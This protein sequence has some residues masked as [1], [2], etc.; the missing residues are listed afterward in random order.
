MSDL[1]PYEEGLAIDLA[2]AHARIE[3]LEAE[4]AR[5]SDALLMLHAAVVE[6]L[7]PSADLTRLANVAATLAELTGGNDE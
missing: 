2:K 4:L 1:N 6:A 3:E 7:Q 5:E